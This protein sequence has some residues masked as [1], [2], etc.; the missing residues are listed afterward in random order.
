MCQ[1]RVCLFPSLHLSA[2]LKVALSFLLC[3]VIQPTPPHTVSYR[4]MIQPK[5]RYNQ[6]LE[7]KFQ[8]LSQDTVEIKTMA[9]QGSDHKSGQEAP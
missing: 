8:D 4:D 9:L 7:S 6:H 5:L 3:T 1:Q 2:V